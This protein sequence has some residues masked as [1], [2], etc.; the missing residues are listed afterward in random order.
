MSL[1]TRKRTIL[2]KIE[3]TYGQ[4]PTPTAQLDALL[5]SNLTVSPMEMTLAE[6]NNVKAYMGN[7]P[8]VLAAI[9]AKVSFDIE[10]AG[11]GTPG[12]APAYDELLRACGL[13]ATTL[14]AAVSGSATAGSA[15]AMTLAAG[16]SAVDGAYVGMTIN[17]TGG[18]G[19]GQS[20]VIASYVGATK[21][22]TFTAA[23][24]TAAAAT[25]AYTIPAQVVYQP[26]SSNL[27]SVAFYVN[28]DSVKHLMLGARGTVSMKA[29]A[30][31]IPM[32]S[33]QF[34]G[35]YT[36]P[37]DSPI[38]SPNLTQYS[39]PLA[40]NNKNTGSVNVSGFL[41]AVVSD[42]SFDLATSVNFRSLP[43]GTESVQLTDRKPT[44][45]ITIEATP[46]ST[47]GATVAKDWW[48]LIKNVVLG[49]FSITH[50]TVAGNI[51]KID[52]PQ[53]Q[54][55]E[56]SYGDKDG[57]TMLTMKQGFNPLNGNDELTIC[58]L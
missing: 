40:I 20:A 4:D 29:S 1:L 13:S 54:L 27:E 22:A 16:A 18:T 3:S 47:G 50:G 33:F 19:A 7:N 8:S 56:P 58:F 17:L 12:T 5:M 26:V 42:F 51:V 44:G 2:A 49:P 35:L 52:A 34:T 6:R 36:T 23:L 28:V 48:T 43:G 10:M 32:F 11:S 15:T 46:V 31:G 55:T 53:Q 25:T 9:Y 41:G 21:V 30:Q 39:Q 45:S 57:V 38:P 24:A 14:A 37:T